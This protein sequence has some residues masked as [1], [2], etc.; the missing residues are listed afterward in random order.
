M[1]LR[2]WWY[3]AK[4]TKWQILLGVF[5]I[6]VFFIIP[7]SL[8]DQL[9]WDPDWKHANFV[10]SILATMLGGVA[11]A[12]ITGVLIIFQNVIGMDR[13]K[14]QKIFDQRVQLYKNFLEQT[15]AIID[16]DVLEDHERK[17]LMVIE[18]DILMIAS[19]ETYN[20]WYDVYRHILKLPRT[21]KEMNKLRDN[22]KDAEEHS[23]RVQKIAELTTYFVN[24]CRKDLQIVPITNDVV[25][26]I[27]AANKLEIEKHLFTGGVDS[28]NKN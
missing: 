6:G 10:D 2:K 25:Q 21:I 28:T 24:Q 13:E 19:P 14:N 18:K 23:N 15:M 17:N 3:D 16:D 26:Q 1:N 27:N 4:T 12:I 11:V 8:L 22:P 7:F 5:I 9:E 20:A